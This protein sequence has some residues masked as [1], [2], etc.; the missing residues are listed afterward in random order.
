M[1]KR[2]YWMMSAWLLVSAVGASNSMPLHITG[3]AML[4]QTSTITVAPVN[5]QRQLQFT[6]QQP[7]T[8]SGWPARL[9]ARLGLQT[10]ALRRVLNPA[11]PVSYLS[12]ANPGESDPWLILVENGQNGTRLSETWVLQLQRDRV[13]L[14]DQA[15]NSQRLIAPGQPVILRDNAGTHWQFELLNVTPA[16]NGTDSTSRASW[17]MRKL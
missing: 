17:Y 4:P 5:H 1:G 12:F 14:V 16:G 15:T 11:G 13:T 8:V 7:I 3:Q 2:Y 9:P 6:L 10:V